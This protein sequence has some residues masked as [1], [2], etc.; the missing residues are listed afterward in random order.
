[1]FSKKSVISFGLNECL[2]FRLLIHHHYFLMISKTAQNSNNTVEK[3]ALRHTDT[4]PF[5]SNIVSNAVNFCDFTFASLGEETLCKEVFSLGQRSVPESVH[6]WL[7]NMKL[8]N[9]T[10]SLQLLSLAEFGLYTPQRCERV[11]MPYSKCGPNQGLS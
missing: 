5:I 7:T 8:S 10:C 1:M 4:P 3:A 9:W 6:I 2:T 11:P